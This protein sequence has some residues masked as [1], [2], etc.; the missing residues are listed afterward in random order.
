MW[1]RG[2]HREGKKFLCVCAVEIGGERGGGRE[3]E[4]KRGEKRSGK[5][6]QVQMCLG[7]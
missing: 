6:P 1:G 2:Q 4:E 7:R 5:G 3:V